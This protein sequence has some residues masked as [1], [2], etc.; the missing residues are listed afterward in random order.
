MSLDT[1]CSPSFAALTP[2]DAALAY[3]QSESLMRYIF[4]RYGASQIT[5]LMNAYADGLECSEGVELALGIPL[6]ELERQ[7]QASLAQGVTQGPR[8]S[9]SAI[10]WLIVWGVSFVVA[11]LF[12]APQPATHDGRPLF[13]TKIA[14]KPV[15]PDESAPGEQ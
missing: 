12:V 8:A 13:D 9:A 5:A 6:N 3:A 1:L 11:L 7:W 15:P 14:L 10:P 4:Q 2:H